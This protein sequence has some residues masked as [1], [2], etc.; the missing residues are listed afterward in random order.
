MNNIIIKGI[1]VGVV[2]ALAIGPI[3]V[4]IIQRVIERGA[5]IGVLSGVGVALADGMFGLIGGLGLSVIDQFLIEQDFWL[6]ISSAIILLIL[7]LSIFFSSPNVNVSNE[8][9]DRKNGAGIITSIFLLTI[10]NPV[11]ILYFASVY[12]N[13]NI[14]SSGGILENAIVFGVSVFVGSFIWWVILSY[15]TGGLRNKLNPRMLSKLNRVTGGII[16]GF[17]IWIIIN[18]FL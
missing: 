10:S 16:L 2:G 7:G 17:A 12:A 15:L 6:R 9:I 11:T 18:L 4:L 13:I 3:A 1:L 5:K 8:E 14:A